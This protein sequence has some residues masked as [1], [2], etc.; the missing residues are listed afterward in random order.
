MKHFKMC[1]THCVL[2]SP[3]VIQTNS[4]IVK[5]KKFDFKEICI[6]TTIIWVK[7]KMR[8]IHHFSNWTTIDQNNENKLICK[9]KN[10]ER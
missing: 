10:R 4:P 7:K 1:N 2:N 8:K 3:N 6:A 5:L 9:E